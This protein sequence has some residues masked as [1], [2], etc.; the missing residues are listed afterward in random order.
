MQFN[1]NP[2]KFFLSGDHC[3]KNFSRKDAL[4]QHERVHSKDGDEG[5]YSEED[6]QQQ[7]QAAGSV[8]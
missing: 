1:V 7:Q 3:G 6:E 8:P 5:A 2:L 4:K